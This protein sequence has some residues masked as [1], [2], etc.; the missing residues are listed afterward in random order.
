MAAELG[1]LMGVVPIKNA[2]EI[3]AAVPEFR[4]AG[5]IHEPVLVAVVSGGLCCF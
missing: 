4:R 1:R 2:P 3:D 5:E